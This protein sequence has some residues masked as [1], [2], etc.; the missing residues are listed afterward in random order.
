MAFLSAAAKEAKKKGV[1]G[2]SFVPSAMGHLDVKTVDKIVLV[3]SGT[4]M[5]VEIKD[6][7]MREGKPLTRDELHTMLMT[8]F[9]DRHDMYASLKADYSN[10]NA[11]APSFRLGLV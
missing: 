3:C 10:L 9:H 7:A 11:L 6:L 2:P 4:H 1:A 8:S 5:T